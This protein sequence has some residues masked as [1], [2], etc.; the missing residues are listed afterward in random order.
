MKYTIKQGRQWWWPMWFF[1]YT[2]NKKFTWIFTPD[3]SMKFNY[4]YEFG[5]SIDE[6]WQ[7]W[8][9]IGGISFVNWKN[10]R[11]ILSKNRDSVML[12]CRWNPTLLTF[13]YIIYE[14]KNGEK[15]PR[16][17]PTQ[18][19]RSNGSVYLDIIPEGNKFKC[20]LHEGD[21]NVNAIIIEPR[22]EPILL[23]YINMWYGGSNNSRGPW[24]G[25]APKDMVCNLDFNVAPS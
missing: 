11:N 18:I 19:L 14:N 6:D 15:F 1:L 20:Y 10:L 17:S 25:K 21:M 12:A 9:K 3:D 23:S 24:G 7:D 16:E 2:T 8:K 4:E 5:Q 22:F 13:E